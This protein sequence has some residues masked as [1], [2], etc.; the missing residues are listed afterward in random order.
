MTGSEELALKLKVTEA[1][2]KDMGR[3]FARMGP[4]DIEKLQVTI[5]DI[6]E[7]EGKRKSVCKVMP[8]YKDLRGQSRIQLDGLSRENVGAGVDEFVRVRKVTCR[9]AE[10]LQLAPINITPA[11]RDLKYIGSLLDGLPVLE[12]DRIRATLFGSRSADFTVETT[13]PKGPVLINPTTQLVIA[14]GGAEETIRSVSYEDIGGLKPQLQ[15]IREM[16]ELPL[17]YPEVFERLGIDAPKGVLLHGP[18]GCGKT[19]IARTIAHET[20]ANFFSINGPEVIHKFYGESEAH[21]RKI[22]EEASRK[23]PSIVFLDEIDAIAPRREKVVGDVEK[24]VVAQLLALMDG[25][26]KRQNVIVICATNI[27]NALD[28]ALRRPGRF[29]REISIPIPDRNGRLEILEIHSRGM[30]LAQNVDMAHLAEITHGFVGA[31][32]EALCRE[33]AMIS[34]RR[35]LPDI[36]FALTQIPYEQL[37][38]LEVYMDDFLDALREV[39]PSAIREVFVEIPDVRWQD[40]GGLGTVKARLIEAVEWPLKYPHLF[41]K[42]GCKPPKGILI[43][44]VPGCGKTLLAKAIATESNVNFISVKGPALLSK[45]VGESESGVREV[46]RKAR[47]AAPC[48][49]FFDEIDALVPVRST[50]SSDS[51]VAERV[52][53]QF[54]SELDGIEELKGVLVLGATNRTDILDPAVLR[55][56]RFDEIIEIPIPDEKDR[57]QIFEVHL[58]NKPLAPNIS[59]GGL[60][61]KTEGFSG[62]DIAGVCHSAALKALRR[63]V[64]K[65]GGEEAG[66]TIELKITK[67]DLH[68]AI[69]EVQ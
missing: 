1:L 30:P 61:V 47:Q 28:P 34:L 51:H 10:R 5:G 11:E 12:G 60:A 27:P 56:G 29:D 15:R 46:F 64:E 24:R 25:L 37:T 67:A 31:D 4:E 69:E 42:A 20:E 32:L 62:A 22:F 9:P 66:D 19:L 55:P 39:E 18:P 54:L 45:Y 48:I 17:R 38:K 40:I 6:L 36:D 44:G 65:G 63:V 26:N 21:L 3:A 52:L 53:S 14:K 23:G 49:I 2:S 8:A 35:I 16:I 58:R 43:S 68:S 33:A 41:E 59:P 13:T 50:G 57:E 7:A